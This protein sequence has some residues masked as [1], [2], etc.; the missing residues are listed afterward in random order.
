MIYF[1]PR[2]GD[3]VYQR[4]GPDGSRTRVQTTYS[5]ISY[6]R[7]S[8]SFQIITVSDGRRF[9]YE[10]TYGAI[11]RLGMKG[12]F[13]IPPPVFCRNRKLCAVYLR[14]SGLIKQRTCRFGIRNAIR[15]QRERKQQ[16]MP[17]EIQQYQCRLFLFPRTRWDTCVIDSFVQPVETKQAHIFTPLLLLY[18]TIVEIF[19]C[20][21]CV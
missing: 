10:L 11:S 2:H 3:G 14:T 17:D 4:G 5:K 9:L 13:I 21:F 8:L 1:E 18:F 19:W 12:L 16:R 6:L 15:L 7:S 20:E